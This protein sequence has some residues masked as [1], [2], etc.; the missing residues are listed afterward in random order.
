MD[1]YIAFLVFCQTLGAFVGACS[2]V[3]AELAYVR[4]ARNGR[5][6]VAERAHLSAIGQGM[7]YGM[8]AV[9]LSSVGLVTAAYFLHAE[10]QPALTAS[11]WTFVVLSSLVIGV[12]WALSRGR[13]PFGVGAAIVFSGWWYLAFLTLGRLPPLSLGAS[14]AVYAVATGLLFGIL[15]YVRMLV[16]PKK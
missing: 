14:L 15:Q 7:R 3:W 10:A 2:A 4:A 9:L 16:V 5:I 12:T 6:S 11:Y 13:I 8:T 1:P